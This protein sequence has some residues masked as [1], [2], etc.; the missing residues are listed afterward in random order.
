MSLSR[1]HYNYLFIGKK[2]CDLTVLN[3]NVFPIL[4]DAVNPLLAYT[5]IK[6]GRIACDQ[7]V[8]CEEIKLG[9]PRWSKE[10]LLPICQNFRQYPDNDTFRFGSITAEFPSID[11]AYKRKETVD[12]Y[13]YFEN[14]LIHHKVKAGG[15]CGFFISLRE[16]IFEA[17]GEALVMQVLKNIYSLFDSAKV[18]FHKRTWWSNSKNESALHDVAPWRAIDEDLSSRYRNWVEIALTT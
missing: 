11:S 15:D 4:M 17:A 7:W 3:D 9:R 8:N 14:D 12:I 16:D 2:Y 6:K 18:L 5:N 10:S 13:F 1:L